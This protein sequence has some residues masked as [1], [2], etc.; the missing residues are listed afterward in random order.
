MSLIVKNLVKTYKQESENL[1]I[2][3][4]LNLEVP[5]SKSISILGESGSG[6]STLLALLAALDSPDSGEIWINGTNIVSLSESEKTSFRAK[7]I[8]IVFQQYHLVDHLTALENVMLPLEIQKRSDAHA[9]AESLLEEMGLA[10][11][12]KHLPSELSGGECQ[13]VAIARALIVEPK[14]LLAD[15]PSGNLDTRTG[16]KV[17]ELFFETVKKH[18]I[19]S[20]LVTHSE[21][22]AQKTETIY[23]LSNGSLSVA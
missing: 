13:R 17:M 1:S 15:E 19:T 21:N 9:R 5:D 12:L 20:I 10:H 3:R 14:L 7:N 8:S 16:H 18:K 2:L 11:R 4:N 22:L 6:K 23:K